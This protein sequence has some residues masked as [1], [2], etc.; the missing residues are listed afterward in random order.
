MTLVKPQEVSRN[1]R[2]TGR[3]VN[4]EI[5]LLYCSLPVLIDVLPSL[6]FLHFG[7]LVCAMHIL[8]QSEISDSLIHAAQSML[9]DFYSLCLEL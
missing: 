1:I 4:S 5:S 6:Y 9:D 2:S 7:L 3:Q 8:L